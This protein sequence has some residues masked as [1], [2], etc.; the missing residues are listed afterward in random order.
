M[1]IVMQDELNEAVRTWITHQIRP[2]PAHGRLAG[3]PNLIF[4]MP[5]LYTA[6]DKL[7]PVLEQE[8]AV[9]KE[10]CTP[11]GQHPCDETVLELCILL[12]DENG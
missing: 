9:C 4:S 6:E 12:M 2:W 11:K 8:K 10:E 1:F 7:Q 3:C 5:Q